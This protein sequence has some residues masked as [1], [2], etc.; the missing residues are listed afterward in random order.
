MSR[1]ITDLISQGE[2]LLLDFKYAINDSRKIARSLSAF[3][4]TKGGKLLIGV[5]DN[6]SIVGV[7]SD[8]EVYMVEAAANFYCKPEV[9]FTTKSWNINGKSVL[10]V[11]IPES[12]NKPHWAQKDGEWLAYVRVKDENILADNIWLS[13]WKMQKS[14]SGIYFKY[15][16]T[17][18]ILMSYL[19][20]NS[21]IS[22]DSFMIIAG[23]TEKEATNVIARLLVLEVLEINY[24]EFGFVYFL[25]QNEN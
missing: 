20:S 14:R 11:R 7:S 16:E 25:K 1:Y 9:D 23:I 6:G 18:Q 22:L 8:E 10:E 12:K 4:N 2:H 19:E 15:S 5:K 13:F 17:E 24:V 21:F 3:A